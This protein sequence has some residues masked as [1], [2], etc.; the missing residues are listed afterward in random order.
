MPDETRKHSQS[1]LLRFEPDQL[2]MIDRAAEHSGLNRTS[3]LRA[4]VIRAAR[5]EMGESGGQGRGKR[6]PSR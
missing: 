4:A 1:V 5:E 6:S 3:W 2:E